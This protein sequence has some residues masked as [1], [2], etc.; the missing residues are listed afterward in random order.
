MVV[1]Q[2][3][4]SLLIVLLLVMLAIP[5]GA[6][7]IMEPLYMQQPSYGLCVILLALLVELPFILWLGKVT[8]GMAILTV[9]VMNFASFVPVFFFTNAGNYLEQAVLNFPA[10]LLGRSDELSS[11]GWYGIMGFALLMDLIIEGLVVG[12]MLRR[13]LGL[14]GWML[15]LGAN[16]ASFALILLSEVVGQRYF[17]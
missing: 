2:R 7:P 12:L 6:D 10:A 17:F 9:I 5:A 3:T 13:S 16:V 4:L 8:I 1:R 14:R 11:S 15:V